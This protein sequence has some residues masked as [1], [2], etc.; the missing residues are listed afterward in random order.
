Y[1]DT[2]HRGEVVEV[3][4]NL[5]PGNVTGARCEAVP[6]PRRP[7]RGL[8]P[9]ERAREETA[10]EDALVAGAPTSLV[11]DDDAGQFDDQVDETGV[12]AVVEDRAVVAETERV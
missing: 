12:I 9:T 3:G 2:E 10:F 1:R 11:F 7:H 6:T 4:R 8:A 5:R